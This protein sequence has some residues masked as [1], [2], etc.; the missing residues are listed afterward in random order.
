MTRRKK[1]KK[2]IF[3]PFKDFYVHILHGMLFF[4]IYSDGCGI[5]LRGQHSK[6]YLFTHN[7]IDK[8]IYIIDTDILLLYQC[9]FLLLD[10]Y[11]FQIFLNVLF[12]NVSILLMYTPAF[13]PH[14]VCS[15]I[16]YQHYPL[17]QVT[18]KLYFVVNRLYFH[19]LLHNMLKL[20]WIS[21]SESWTWKY[22]H[23]T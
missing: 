11:I 3:L 12:A 4:H 9:I 17:Y 1:K 10:R 23:L 14:T 19:G 21:P 7:I 20:S 13:W 16:L 5:S 18:S 6:A 15:S 22:P 8:K 2:V